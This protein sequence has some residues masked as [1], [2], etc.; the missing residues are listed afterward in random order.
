MTIFVTPPPEGNTRIPPATA[1][2]QAIIVMWAVLGD[3]RQLTVDDALDLV[4][5]AIKQA[6]WKIVPREETDLGHESPARDGA[7]DSVNSSRSE[8]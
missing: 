2:R 8:R 5:M 7:P 3:P 1:I 4:L 6:G